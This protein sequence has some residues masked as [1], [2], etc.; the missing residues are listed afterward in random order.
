[1]SSRNGG[2]GDGSL[3]REEGGKLKQGY[4]YFGYNYLVKGSP[5]AAMAPSKNVL[6][7][8]RRGQFPSFCRIGTGGCNN[9]A[10]GFTGGSLE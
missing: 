7:T 3:L 2:G 8:V 9:L 1:V 5:F 6:A 10:L 4:I